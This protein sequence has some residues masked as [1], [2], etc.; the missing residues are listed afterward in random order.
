MQVNTGSQVQYRSSDRLTEIWLQSG[1]LALD[2]SRS[3]GE[4]RLYAADKVVD[5]T[6][7]V[8]NARLR[9]NFLDLAVLSGTGEV[10]PKDSTSGDASPHAAPTIVR[11]NHAVLT[12]VA[13]DVVRPLDEMDSGV[14]TAWPKG[15]LVFQGQTLETAVA[16]YNRYLVHKIVIADGS[17]AGT[18]LGGRFTTHDP[19]AFLKVLNESFGIRAT[20]DGQG[21]ITLTK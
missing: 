14:I 20:D 10:R 6:S 7:A 9:G 15:E 5:L 3:I 4:C 13:Q 12:S 16:E 8:V 2:L 18:Q 19:A 1:E 17:I 21:N 11:A